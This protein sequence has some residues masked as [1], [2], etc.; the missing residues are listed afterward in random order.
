MIDRDFDRR[1]RANMEIALD[2]ACVNVS[3][4]EKDRA[5]KY[6]A[7]HIV[8]C[9]GARSLEALTEAGLTAAAEFRHR[10]MAE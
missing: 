6:V 5:R 2:R 1:T 7:D 4:G 8:K 10:A 3:G 9:A